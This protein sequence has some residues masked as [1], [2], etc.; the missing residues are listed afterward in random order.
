MSGFETVRGSQVEIAYERHG[1]AEGWPVVLL[2]GF[3]YDPRCYDEVAARLAAS[4]ADV[5]VPYLRGYGPSTYLAPDVPRSGQQAALA[6]DLCDLITGLALDRPIVAGFDWGGRAACVASMLRPD[7]VSGLVT[8]GGYNVHDIAAMAT[9]PD[10][11]VEE[12]RNWYQWYFHSERGRAGL[13]RN[14]RALARQLWDEWSP[15]WSE[16]PGV[17][18]STAGSFD[19]PDF[20]ATVVHF[21]RHRYGLV[22]GDPVH[23]TD[24][25]LIARQP[26]IAVPSSTRQPTRSR[27]RR[28]PR[29]TSST[30]LPWSN[31]GSSMPVTTCRRRPPSPSPTRS[32]RSMLDAADAGGLR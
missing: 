26:P 17:F 18:E 11:P 6:G 30:S 25:A 29:R 13:D 8:V 4:G 15:T 1:D 21:Y 10:E 14:R 2:H 31:T 12:R 32:S 19:N 16:P 3:P 7:L 9:V 5:V 27:R 28:P 20:V 24:E 23:E 22:P